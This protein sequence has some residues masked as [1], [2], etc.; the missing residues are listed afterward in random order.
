MLIVFLTFMIV[1]DGI[2]AMRTETITGSA[3]LDRVGIRAYADTASAPLSGPGW[4]GSMDSEVTRD[5]T[6]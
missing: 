1:S 6:T 3:F 4:F 5:P 2:N